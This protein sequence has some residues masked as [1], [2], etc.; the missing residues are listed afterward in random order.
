ME[1]SLLSVTC[2]SSTLIPFLCAMKIKGENILKIHLCCCNA[3]LQ[4][5]ICYCFE[6]VMCN[7]KSGR[8][9]VQKACVCCSIT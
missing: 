3:I 4:I 7:P 6:N 9:S 5:E 1:F 8:S 2:H